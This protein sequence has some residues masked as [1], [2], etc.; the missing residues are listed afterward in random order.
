MRV[1]EQIWKENI[2]SKVN[3]AAAVVGSTEYLNVIVSKVLLAVIE[4][5][6]YLHPV[7]VAAVCKIIND[8]NPAKIKF[9]RLTISTKKAPATV[10]TQ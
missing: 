8:I 5:V 10:K 4:G 9:R 3:A 1:A 7:I 6:S 2:H